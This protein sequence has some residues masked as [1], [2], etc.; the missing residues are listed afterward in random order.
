MDGAYNICN[1]SKVNGKSGFDGKFHKSS[2][3]FKLKCT[4]CEKI[5]IG[6]TQYITKKSMENYISDVHNLLKN[7]INPD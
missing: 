5:L 2:L 4:L 1:I 6:N 3:I 7:I